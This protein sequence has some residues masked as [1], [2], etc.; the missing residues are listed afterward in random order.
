MKFL[1]LCTTLL[2]S[3]VQADPASV[4]TTVI[5]VRGAAGEA[6]YGAK[7]ETQLTAWKKAAADAGAEVITPVAATPGGTQ[8]AALEKIL[9][10]IPKDGP[11]PL[12]LVMIGH[13]T[14]DGKDAR[15]NL[16]G[17]DLPGTELAGW[18]RPVRRPLTVINTSSCS[19]PFLPLLAG[20]G[21]TIITATRSGS[22]RNYA[23]FGDFFAAVLTDPAADYDQDGTHS[24]LEWF[25]RASSLT[26]EFYQSE[27][28]LVTEHALIDDNGDG[29]GTPAEWFRGLRAIAKAKD[30]PVD[31]TAAHQTTLTPDAASRKMTA[32]QLTLRDEL[33]AKIAALRL[34]KEKLPEAEYFKQLEDLLRELAAVYQD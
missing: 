30:T 23:R 28:R 22:E 4:R 27:G 10:E 12:W 29:K 6:A 21:R 31:G 11:A 26:A 15:F 3:A 5:V 16:E 17:P 32:A 7:F 2:T 13:G 24:V 25:L 8:H 14:W 20:P 18:L 9:T 33:E 19:A 1:L 34:Q